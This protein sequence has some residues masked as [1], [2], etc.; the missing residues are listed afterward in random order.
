MGAMMQ[1]TVTTTAVAGQFA[2]EVC[3]GLFR[4][5]QKELPSKY[6]YDA[7]GSAL[8]EVICTLPE[9]GL[10]RAEESV[11]RAHARDIVDQLPRPVVVAE[12]GSGT[13][14]KTRLLLE[15]LARW[16]STWYHPIEISAAALAVCRREL[17]DIN[18]VSVVGFE[19]EYLDGL[20]EA[21][22]R[23]AKGEHVLVLF[24]GSTVGNFDGSSGGDFLLQMRSILQTG[25]SL[26]LGTDLIKPQDVLIPAYDDALGVTAAFNRN[27]L[28]R[29]NRE[30]KAN[31]DLRA[32]EHRA[33]FNP[34]TQ[35]V[36]MHLRSTKRQE[37]TIP[38]A[39]AVEFKEGE[40]IWTET[41]HK[42]SQE[43]LKSLA[44][45]AGFS[46]HAQW[47]EPSWGFAENLWIAE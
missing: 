46:Q 16:Q 10:T 43:E 11:L 36:E 44:R 34:D 8:F 5:G 42:Y 41:S 12:L 21:V 35:S 47:I 28:V 7:V 6:L 9:Y 39:G 3:A 32:F 13:G 31:F 27:L 19:R 38:D 14:R 15:A 25:D 22:A 45:G 2:A 24:L 29:I 37:V 23:R 40:T 26:L 18:S 4:T 33:V 17:Q 1:K 20:R 30:L